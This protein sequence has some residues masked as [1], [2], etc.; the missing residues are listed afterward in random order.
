MCKE[1]RSKLSVIYISLFLRLHTTHYAFE[2]DEIGYWYVFMTLCIH[3]WLNTFMIIMNWRVSVYELLRFGLLWNGV[4][5]E[6]AVKTFA[7]MYCTPTRKKN[8]KT[9]VLPFLNK[10]TELESN[11]LVTFMHAHIHNAGQ[12]GTVRRNVFRH[13]LFNYEKSARG[14]SWIVYLFITMKFSHHNK[15]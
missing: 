1:N 11:F 5:D 14:C 15:Y 6:W 3:A 13:L 10:M 12:E 2:S 4:D 7:R 8:Q 9:F